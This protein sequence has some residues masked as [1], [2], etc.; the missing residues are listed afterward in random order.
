MSVS[1]SSSSGVFANLLCST[2]TPSSCHHHHQSA[3][4]LFRTIDHLYPVM[5][6]TFAPY[7]EESYRVHANT[8]KQNNFTWVV[9]VRVRVCVC[10]C[11]CV[12][13][14]ACVVFVL[15]FNTWSSVILFT[16]RRFWRTTFFK[17]RNISLT[18][19]RLVLIRH[20]LKVQTATTHR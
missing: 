3:D 16:S 12:C 4:P 9:C 7:T 8:N 19:G 14:R 17:C 6:S 18:L 20:K 5:S 1:S 13:V 2:P 15:I 11:V 10:P